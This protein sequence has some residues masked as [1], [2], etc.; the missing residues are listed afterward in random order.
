MLAM[1]AVHRDAVA[2]TG[3][4]ADHSHTTASVFHHL[5][6]GV[7]GPRGVPQ[8]QIHG[9]DDVR[10]PEQVVVSTGAGAVTPP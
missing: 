8:I 10:A 1:A 2:S 3:G 5:W 6:A 7:L 9:F 4:T